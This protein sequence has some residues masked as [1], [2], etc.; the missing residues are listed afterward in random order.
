M[1]SIKRYV[2]P[3]S[4]LDFSHFCVSLSAL[5]CRQQGWYYDDCIAFGGQTN[6][7]VDLMVIFFRRFPH[8]KP[9][10]NP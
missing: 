10:D 4:L 1:A 3:A 5:A 9:E 2:L 7:H 6:E 8:F